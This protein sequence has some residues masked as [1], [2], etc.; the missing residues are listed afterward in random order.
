MGVGENDPVVAR[1]VDVR[2]WAFDGVDIGFGA[3]SFWLDEVR[4]GV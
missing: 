4:D 1:G 2:K 3:T